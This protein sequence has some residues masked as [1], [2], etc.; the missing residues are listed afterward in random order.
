MLIDTG[1]GSEACYAELT[2]QLAHIGISLSTI[3]TIFLTHTHPDHV[4]Q[5]KRLLSETA[6]QLLLH[7][8]E[9]DQLTRIAT[10]GEKPLWLDSILHK[11]GVPAEL[12]ERIEGSFERIRRN[13][14]LLTPTQILSG[15]EVLDTAIGPLHLILTPGHSPGHL[16]LY[17]PERKLLLAGDHVLQ[18][19]TPNI[20]WL[21]DLDPLGD[22]HRSLDLLIPYEIDLIL[23]GH[24]QPF[25]DHRQYVSRTKAHHDERCAQILA[26]LSS[27]PRSAHQLVGDLWTRPLA[28]FHH[29]FAVFEVLAHLEFLFR[30]DQVHS[31][32]D[33]AV[34]LWRV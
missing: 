2:A 13:F 12:T 1:L 9:L 15:G 6:A 28:P 20:G 16:C 26:S 33:Q 11:A 22:F 5:A 17:Q 21:P 27:G 4:G 18:S 32:D 24:G 3:R 30:R 31:L 25:S 7:S 29:R 34:Q 14:Q 8:A 23:P 19:I 10:S